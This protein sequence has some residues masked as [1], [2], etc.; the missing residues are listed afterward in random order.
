M[1]TR[2]PTSYIMAKT[3]KEKYSSKKLDELSTK[4]RNAE[5]ALTEGNKDSHAKLLIEALDEDEYKKATEVI[6][7]LKKLKDAAKDAE[8]DLLFGA[9]DAIIKEINK[10]TGGGDLARL[11]GKISSL[12][13][14]T[15]A[16]NPIL[17]GLAMAEVLEKGFEL[18]PTILKN[19]ISDIETNKEKQ[20]MSLDD[21]VKDDEALKKNILTN[22]EKAFVP[23]GKFGKVFGKIPGIDNKKLITDL[24]S[25]TPEKLMGFKKLL[26]AGPQVDD[27]PVELTNPKEAGAAVA[28]GKEGEKQTP[29][30]E[31]QNVVLVQTAAKKAGIKEE[32]TVTRFL[33]NMMGFKEGIK[34]PYADTAIEVLKA[35]A[36]GAKVADGQLDGFVD[37]LAIDKNKVVKDI[38][39]RITAAEKEKADKA[40]KEA[41]KG[42]AAAGQAGALAAG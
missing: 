29:E 31:K 34:H 10:Y 26:E 8:M 33:I 12:F 5:L 11:G 30:Q 39:D 41:E 28:A 24:M 2:K 14:K 25:A 27:L 6:E 15:P 3:L 32:E 19:N 16:K 4:V 22:L 18:L 1:G 37:G 21:A 36:T 35:Y 7:K 23:S 42:G 13:S 40:A 9:I 38:K 17:A 20:K